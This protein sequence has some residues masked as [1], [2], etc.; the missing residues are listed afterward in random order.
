[1]AILN[2]VGAPLKEHVT[3]VLSSS[4]FRSRDGSHTP[5][6]HVLGKLAGTTGLKRVYVLCL[7]ATAQRIWR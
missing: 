2:I 3:R 7:W 1:M 5:E 6:N 4:A